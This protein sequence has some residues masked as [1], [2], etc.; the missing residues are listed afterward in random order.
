MKNLTE[1][2]CM[3]CLR[4]VP[5]DG[6]GLTQL[7]R[8]CRSQPSLNHSLKKQTHTHTHTHTHTKKTRKKANRVHQIESE[9]VH[10]I[11]LWSLL[12]SYIRACQEIESQVKMSRYGKDEVF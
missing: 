11:N 7:G 12:M 4:F 1:L 5:S 10:S 8:L 6:V 9:L 2:V 3:R